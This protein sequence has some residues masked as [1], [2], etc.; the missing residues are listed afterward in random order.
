[1]TYTFRLR[2][3]DDLLTEIRRQAEACGLQAGYVACCV[4]CVSR[5][6][7][8]DAGGV[9]YHELNEPMEI[10]SLTGTVSI[11]RCHLHAVFSKRDLSTVGGHLG[12]G[13]TI[14]TTAEVILVAVDQVAFG[15]AFDPDT[16]F[17]ELTLQTPG[18]AGDEPPACAAAPD[19]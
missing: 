12:E 14:N 1:M 11:N 15:S 10:V 17:Y 6:R 16:G 3:G 19:T 7:L 18:P 13:C 9:D 8:R 2:R 4:G 5:A